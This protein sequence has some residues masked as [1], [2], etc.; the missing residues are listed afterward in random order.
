MFGIGMQELLLIL[1]VALIV[2]GPKRLPEVAKSL[3]KAMNEFKRAASDIKES[4]DLEDG[5]HHVKKSFDT[6]NK[7]PAVADS[8][9]SATE[10]TPVTPPSSSVPEETTPKTPEPP[11]A[12]A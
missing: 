1:V 8:H 4:L 5:M 7:P 3:G 10:D 9:A 11:H 12:A 6:M 2:L